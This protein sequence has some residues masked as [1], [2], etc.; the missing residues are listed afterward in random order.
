MYYLIFRKTENLTPDE[1]NISKRGGVWLHTG[2]QAET[3][4]QLKAK[5]KQ[6]KKD[7]QG[8]LGIGCKTKIV[9]E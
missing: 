6:L 4:T 9:S 3:Q 7:G 5:I 8:Y 2:V 1:K